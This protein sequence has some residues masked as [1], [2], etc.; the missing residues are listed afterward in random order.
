MTTD[1]RAGTAA[2]F[3]RAAPTYDAVGADFFTPV[4]RS[5]VAAAG[6]RPG[7]R[8][9]DVGCGR[10]ACLFPA[11]EMVGRNGTV[12][13]IDLSVA[14]VQ[15]TATDVQQRGLRHVSV[16]RMDAQEPTLAAAS[17]D[18]VL[19]SL[20]LFFLPDPAAG[21]AAW[22]AALRPGGRL[23]ITTFGP[24][25]ARWDVLDEVAKRYADATG[26]TRPPG[27]GTG[28]FSSADRLA[29]LLS[30]AGFTN[31]TSDERPQEVRFSNGEHWW[32][33]QW[34]TGA[35][36][37]WEKLPGDVLPAAKAAAI[38]AAE[39]AAAEPDGTLIWRPTIRYTTAV[40]A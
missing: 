6:L 16:E 23:A 18:A 4:G 14:M 31:I 17:Y 15:A 20:V 11:A 21:L 8:V 12:L 13:G 2:V 27:S 3:D 37:I 10:G 25:D 19:A 32:R 29:E 28:P 36:Y 30:P 39:R 40:K 26:T 5:L 24:P 38:A 1:S 9:L 22:A 34:S 35:R 33:W 7:D